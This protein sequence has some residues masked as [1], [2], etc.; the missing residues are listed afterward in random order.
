[1]LYLEIAAVRL[2]DFVFLQFT[3][4]KDAYYRLRIIK[5]L[6]IFLAYHTRGDN[7]FKIS[8]SIPI[9]AI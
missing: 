5:T 3:L 2:L 4:Q 8:Q 6:Y 9:Y 7:V 1:M